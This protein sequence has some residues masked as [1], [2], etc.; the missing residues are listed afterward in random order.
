MTAQQA[1]VQ[2]TVYDYNSIM[3]YSTTSFTMN[4]METM[5]AKFDRARPL[6]GIKMSDLDILE[7]NKIYQCHGMDSELF[8][9]EQFK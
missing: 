5:I 8:T 4:G 2:G 3:H 9:T 1:V 7:L 6:G